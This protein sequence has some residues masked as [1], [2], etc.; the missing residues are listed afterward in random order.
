MCFCISTCEFLKSHGNERF[1]VKISFIFVR[2]VRIDWRKECMTEFILFYIFSLKE[3]KNILFTFF[4][5][6]ATFAF[7]KR[8]S[9]FQ[10]LL[11]KS[12]CMAKWVKLNN[13][14]QPFL[15]FQSSFISFNFLF[16]QYFTRFTLII[17]LLHSHK[18]IRTFSSWAIWPVK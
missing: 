11:W 18:S 13:I 7:E 1:W 2:A 14:W 4:F 8:F 10:S 3:G 5:G 9:K 15:S 12:S 17:Y 16:L 6:W